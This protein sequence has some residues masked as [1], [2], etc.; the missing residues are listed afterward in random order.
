MQNYCTSDRALWQNLAWNAILTPGSGSALHIS[1]PCVDAQLGC[2]W[3]GQLV[4]LAGL[5]LDGQG[6]W[7]SNDKVKPL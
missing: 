4:G 1:C 5:G 3:K 2:I 6:G 7:D